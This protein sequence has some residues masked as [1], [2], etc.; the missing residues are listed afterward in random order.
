M[1]RRERGPAQPGR[2][3]GPPE[4]ARR[5]RSAAAQAPELTAL[6]RANDPRR[7]AEIQARLAGPL[8]SDAAALAVATLLGSAYPALGRRLEADPG[9]AAALASESHHAARDR[10]GLLAR[11]RRAFAS[12]GLAGLRRAAEVE[13]ARIALREL[14]PASLGGA[15]VDVTARELSHL[16]EATLEVALEE[17]I[18]AVSERLGPLRAPTGEPGRFVV[19][20]MG[21]LGGG[22]LNAGSDVDLV[23]FYD[24]DEA[25]SAAPDGT[26]TPAFEVWTRVAR[27]LTATLEEST[28]E[29][30][31]WR[32]DLR[33]RPEGRTGPLVNSLAAAE[34]YYE[35]F[36]RLWERAALLRARPV[37]GDLGFG[38]EV[39]G[40]LASFVWRRRVDPRIAV[41]MVEL[42]K[43]SRAQLSHDPARDLK[44]GPGGIRE[45][46]FFAQT[47]QLI[48]GGSEPR[49]RAKGTLD[50]LRRLRA[51]GLVTDREGRD[52]ADAYLALRRAEHAVQVASGVQTHLVPD[53]PADRARLARALGFADE[54]AFEADLRR[55]T[56]RVSARFASLLPS[57]APPASRWA[58]AIAVID[59][60]DQ[61]AGA[62]AT[63]ADRE[64]LRQAL[65]RAGLSE[66]GPEAGQGD[67]L[68]RDLL[69]LARHPDA[70][71][72]AR[73]RV[74]HGGLAEVLLDAVADAADPEQAA[75]YLRITFAHL[76]HPGVYA[77]LLG[78]DPR[79]VH[80]LVVTLGA[81]AYLG[82]AVSSNPE[83]VDLVLSTRGAPTPEAAEAEVRAAV[84]DRPA[85]EEDDEEAFVGA[86][87]RA[88]AR[89]TLE[90]GLADLAEEVETRAATAV[91][92]ALADAELEAATRYALA[93]AGQGGSPADVEATAPVR[94][95][96]VLAMGKLGG[97][98]L[99]YGSD[100]DVIFLYD[101][102]AA[103]D[104]QDPGA[105]FARCAR[106]VIRLISI[107]HPS[108]PGYELDTRLRP[109]GSQGLLVTSIDAFARYHGLGGGA[110]AAGEPHPK[111]ATWERL[112]LLRARAAAG[113]PAL[114]AEALAIAAATAYGHSGDPRE[115]AAEVQRLRQR[116]ERELG[117]ERPGRHDLKLGRGGL[118]DIE[119]AVQLLQVLHGA[120]PRVRSSETS[121]ALEALAGAGHLG[122]DEAEA[123]A[124]GYAFLRRLEQRIR[125]VHGDAAHLLEERA[126]GVGPLARRMGIRDRPRA[127]AAAELC[128]R[129]VDVTGR[130]RAAYEAIVEGAMRGQR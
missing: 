83:L 39:L 111:S 11:M 76:R 74:A 61:G 22:E 96:A 120:D 97:R 121:V 86:L 54:A 89:V 92:S 8:G 31:L 50:A 23:F 77:R 18:A 128:A 21:K 75:R 105:Y 64:A 65:V 19:L 78:D 36:G 127:E 116:M 108:G 102:A 118:T 30:M 27:R 56:E 79:A 4:P 59:G 93:A 55:R 2:P 73:S 9:I 62:V 38:E 99:G 37:A 85:D 101:P 80:R 90:V 10:K 125:I 126:P 58:A 113:D 70:P 104:G 6:A 46:E 44:L 26:R 28:A 109:S 48:W 25:E 69:E 3:D 100:L 12:A 107:S 110:A 52:V 57:E 82:R 43:Q 45:A 41:E 112:A 17:A 88:K 106:R 32:V 130:V 67:D 91:L 119:F 13:R 42:A 115:I 24:S 20:G 66:A 94:G 47:L 98:E 35:S 124:E 1:T 122:R 81:S 33:L 14:C 53:V 40:A 15:D 60:L 16:A 34:R 87:R 123:L 129:Y 95:L 114:G 51:A 103:P 5:S 49:V 29:G 7:A 117:H 72:G 71:F 63:Q 84:R 68:A